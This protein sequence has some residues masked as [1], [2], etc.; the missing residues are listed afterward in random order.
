MFF[1][2]WSEFPG[3]DR[4]AA[5]DA[6]HCDRE[7]KPSGESPLQSL[8]QGFRFAMSDLPIRSALL[9]LS[10]LSLFGLQYSVFLPIYA[11]DI[12]HGGAQGLW[13]C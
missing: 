10:V 3:G 4:G 12:L 1:S 8:M 7:S 13:D 9:L 11:H 6:D 2:E 5:G